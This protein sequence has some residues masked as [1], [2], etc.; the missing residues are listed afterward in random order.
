MYGICLIIQDGG[1]VN[2]VAHILQ[3]FW[4]ISFIMYQIEMFI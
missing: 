3:E 2:C 4:Q 1:K